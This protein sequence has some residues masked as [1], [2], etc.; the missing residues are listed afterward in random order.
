MAQEQRC[1]ECGIV[2]YEFH[3][4]I[5]TTREHKPTCSKRRKEGLEY[6]MKGDRVR[7]KKMYQDA[8]WKYG[9]RVF[10]VGFVGHKSPE[11]FMMEQGQLD[12]GD[13]NVF[14]WK[15]FEKVHE[16]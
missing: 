3:D 14:E 11:F 6:F 16:E 10:T 15:R 9:D 4:G 5:A 8:W 7:C 1:E 13:C 12:E 2:V